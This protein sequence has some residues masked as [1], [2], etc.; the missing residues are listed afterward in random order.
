MLGD[1][2]GLSYAMNPMTGQ[3]ESASINPM[4]GMAVAEAAPTYDAATGQWMQTATDPMTGMPAVDPL[5]GM[6]AAAAPM[7]IPDPMAYAE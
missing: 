6:P 1:M 5:T 3:W 7:N 2:T 4:T